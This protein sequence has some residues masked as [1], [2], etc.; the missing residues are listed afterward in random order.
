MVDSQRARKRRSRL[1]AIAVVVALTALVFTATG[2]SATRRNA[3]AGQTQGVT[4]TEIKVG[5]LVSVD[6]PVSLPLGEI[7]DGAQAYFDM[8]NAKGGVFGRKITIVAKHNDAAS[9]TQNVT[10]AR[11]L[12]E[13]D[14]VFAVIPVASLFF[15]GASAL[16]QAGVPAF[17]YPISNDWEGPANLFGSGGS[18][19][20]FQ[21]VD[22]TYP[23][24]AHKLGAKTVAILAYNI[25]I[26]KDCASQLKLSYE[27]YGIKVVYLD[28]ALSFGFPIS[29]IA[30][31]VD[32]VRKSGAQLVSSCLDSNGSLLAKEAINQAGL[33]IPFTW[34]EGYTKAFVER[35]GDKLTGL[36]LTIHEQPFEDTTPTP[37]MRMFRAAIKKSGGH[38][39]EITLIGW[40][41]ADLFVTGLRKAGKHLTRQGLIDAINSMKSFDAHGL[42]APTN[43]TKAHKD[44][45]TQLNCRTFVTVKQSKFVPEF[46]KPGK[47]FICLPSGAKSLDDFTI[48]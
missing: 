16:E 40:I 7:Y 28:E 47:P 27:K 11:T 32:A 48:R 19:E 26:S 8:V 39:D 12:N 43:W 37:G 15:S 4:K 23:W 35:F 22:A 3:P 21:C 41:N 9:T 24:L 38:L 29:A 1:C 45:P 31:D 2:A 20:C 6:N 30:P 5:G 25:D 42:I 10:F 14:G 33:N 17:G 34:G 18:A 13:E 36:H 46:G 44:D